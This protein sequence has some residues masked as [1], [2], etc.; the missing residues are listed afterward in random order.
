[1]VKSLFH[2]CGDVC[3]NNLVGNFP[4]NSLPLFV[5]DEIST[6]RIY[7]D[8]GA[9]KS[10]GVW[11]RDLPVGNH[12]HYRDNKIQATS[13]WGG[14]NS[15]RHNYYDKQGHLTRK[16]VKNSISEVETTYNQNGDVLQEMTWARV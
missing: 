13:Y 14:E 12:I 16:I 8:D 10:V 6:D 11:K 9:V 1:M 7:Y 3:R 5:L 15:E 2:I 4:T